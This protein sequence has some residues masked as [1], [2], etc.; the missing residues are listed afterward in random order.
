MKTKV[1]F[2]SKNDMGIQIDL[3]GRYNL[4]GN[5]PF[6]EKDNDA[7]ELFLFIC[8]T[9]RQLNNLGQQDI[10][11]KALVGL[12]VTGSTVTSLLENNVEIP[13]GETLLNQVHT[14]AMF[15]LPKKMATA[16]YLKISDALWNQLTYNRGFIQ[17]LDDEIITK[18]PRLV[19]YNGKSKRSFEVTMPPFLL[20]AKGFG[21]LGLDIKYYAFHSVVGLIRFLGQ[22]HINDKGFIN[23]FVEVAN[24]CGIACVFN[25]VPTVQVPLANAILQKVNIP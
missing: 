24:H 21:F 25:Q 1:D 8:F 18:V 5:Y 14:G 11:S 6:L 7:A 23:K 10:T 3:S 12:L 19:E 22:K 20:N 16:E 2:Y 13:S 9:L 15:S 17:Y 4:S